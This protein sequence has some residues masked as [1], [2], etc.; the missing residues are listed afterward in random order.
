M[1]QAR[2]DQDAGRDH[3]AQHRL[4]DGRRGLRGALPRDAPGHARERV[5]RARQ[6][7]PL[8]HGLRARRGRQRDLRRALLAAPARL[9]RP[10]CCAPATRPTSTSSTAYMGYRTCYYRTFAVGSASR[11]R[12]ST[13]TSAAATILD[14]AIALIR[15]GA[16]TAEVVEVWPA[17]RGV[18]L[19]RR[20]GGVRAPVR[21]RRRPLDLGEAGLQPARLARPPR[22][23]RGGDGLRARDLLAGDRR[24]VGGADRGAARRH[25]RRLRGDHA[26]PRGGAARRR[27]AASTRSAARCRP[28]AR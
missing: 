23:D 6:Q 17:R 11:P 13:P 20:G 27:R 10:R 9:H 12:W 4:L 22:D 18:R 21:A 24:L 26:L 5:R 28:S 14:E 19:P 3:A 8:R 16:T 7:G 15:P 1:Q 2:E 25:A